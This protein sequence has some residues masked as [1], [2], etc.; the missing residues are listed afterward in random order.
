MKNKKS[1]F[2]FPNYT[3]G[4]PYQKLL[5]QPIKD[6]GWNVTPG[7]IVSAI[8]ARVR[9]D[10]TIFHIH[11]LNAF[12]KDCK[13]VAD[14]WSVVKTFILTL[15]RFQRQGG[16]VMWTIHNHLPHEN[17]FAEQDLRIRHF[18][19]K[20]ADRIHLHCGS[21]IGSLHYLPISLEKVAIHRHGNYIGYYGQFDIRKR[22]KTVRNDGASVLFLGMLRGYKSIDS[23]LNTVSQLRARAIPVTIAGSP[24]TPEIN[25]KIEKFARL[26][27]VN[28]ILRR[29]TE[30]EVHDLCIAHTVGLLS[31]DQILTSGTLKLYL[32]YG[33]AIISPRLSTIECEDRFSTFIY[34]SDKVGVD[35]N[36]GAII[37]EM[38]TEAFANIVELNYSL[39]QESRWSADLFS[40]LTP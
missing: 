40:G 38:K 32:S 29:L 5:Y 39:A 21:H 36:V 27:G 28:V 30:N 20:H 4:N 11:W 22:L 7:G 1:L 15:S 16:K 19:C 17:P 14:A 23:L 9:G 31:Y 37:S 13:S 33:L 34:T 25:E 8:D 35:L 12:F 18:L 2:F 3:G 26:N 10:I 6:A 24:E